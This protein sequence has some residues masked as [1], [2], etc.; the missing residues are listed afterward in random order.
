MD[1]NNEFGLASVAFRCRQCG[2]LY[3]IGCT[4]RATGFEIIQMMGNAL[5][6]RCQRCDAPGRMNY[7]LESVSLST[8]ECEMYSDSVKDR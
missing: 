7:V 5:L 2:C 4:N 1:Q 6:Q 3:R 8:R